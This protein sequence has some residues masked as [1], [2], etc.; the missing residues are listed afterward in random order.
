[1]RSN[2]RI[3]HLTLQH[4]GLFLYEKAILI[5]KNE[6]SKNNISGKK[7]IKFN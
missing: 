1:M 7:T 4:E 3:V 6:I 2:G 5:K